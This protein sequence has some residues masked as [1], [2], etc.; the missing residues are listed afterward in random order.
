MLVTQAHDSVLAQVLPSCHHQ[1]C[2]PER[3]TAAFLQYLAPL[4][5]HP[6]ETTASTLEA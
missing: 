2:E 1:V 4:V 3:V 6:T 5:A